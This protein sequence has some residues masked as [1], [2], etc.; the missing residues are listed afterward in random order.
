[1]MKKSRQSISSD[2]RRKSKAQSTKKAEEYTVKISGPPALTSDEELLKIL[3]IQEPTSNI[4]I[5]RPTGTVVTPDADAKK[6]QHI[7]TA[8]ILEKLV[9]LNEQQQQEVLEYL[10]QL[11]INTGNE[12]PLQRYLE[13]L[14]QQ[15]L[16]AQFTVEKELLSTTKQK[17]KWDAIL[18]DAKKR[19]KYTWAIGVGVGFLALLVLA[20]AIV[21]GVLVPPVGA[22]LLVALPVAGVAIGKAVWNHVKDNEINKAV[23][24]ALT[25]KVSGTGGVLEKMFGYRRKSKVKMLVDEC[26]DKIES[27]TEAKDREEREIK[28]IDDVKKV[29]AGITK[30]STKITCQ[31]GLA[32]ITTTLRHPQARFQSIT[33]EGKLNKNETNLLISSL[34]TN[35]TITEL[36]VHIDDSVSNNKLNKLERELAK[37]KIINCYLRGLPLPC[38]DKSLPL[39]FHG[40]R[41]GLQQAALNKIK[42]GFN[43][44]TLATQLIELFETSEIPEVKDLI[45]KEKGLYLIILS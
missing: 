13:T 15:H 5:H 42:E 22:M 17:Q 14:K 10:T 2:G 35:F 33:L 9:D 24:A 31:G 25:G 30:G 39:Y 44:P 40:G 28:I 32:T 18:E 34:A 36:S 3:L 16:N 6:Y 4:T 27:Q 1:M 41:A 7:I 43:S 12:E 29:L 37:Q 23:D 20:V 38:D 45:Q 26:T 21:V 11:S 8:A 19:G